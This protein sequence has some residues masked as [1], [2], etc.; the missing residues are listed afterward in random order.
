MEDTCKE[1]RVQRNLY[2]EVQLYSPIVIVAQPYA[3]GSLLGAF[4]FGK[5]ASY[6]FVYSNTSVH[7]LCH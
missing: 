6:M 1:D 7:C 3:C 4:E 5:V 2:D